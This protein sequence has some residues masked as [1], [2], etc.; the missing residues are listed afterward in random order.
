MFLPFSAIRVASPQASVTSSARVLT[1]LSG[2][3]SYRIRT[4][5]LYQIPVANTFLQS[6]V[7]LFHP[8]KHKNFEFLW[9][10]IHQFFNFPFSQCSYVRNLCLTQALKGGLCFL[11]KV[12]RRPHVWVY[13][14]F[15]VTVFLR[16]ASKVILFRADVQLF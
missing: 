8:L 13:D 15:S 3:S 11:I 14:P 6:T 7:F 2:E 12:C 16:S 10:S 5:V 9:G 4:R 1:G